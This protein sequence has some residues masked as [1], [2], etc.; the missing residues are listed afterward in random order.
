MADL[1]PTTGAID[2]RFGTLSG[3]QTASKNAEDI[4]FV[5]TPSDADSGSVAYG[6]IFVNNVMFGSR[7]QDLVI[8]GEGTG[9][10]I[11]FKTLSPTGTEL[12][13]T[14]PMAFIT[15]EEHQHYDKTYTTVNNIVQQIGA[16]DG[17]ILKNINVNGVPGNVSN[18]IASVT[19]DATQIAMGSGDASTIAQKINEAIDT[20]GVTSFA[21]QKGAIT[22]KGGSK[23]KGAVN[24]TMGGNDGKELQAAIVGLGTAA[25]EPI[26]SFADASQGEKADS[27][28][29]SI[30][31][32][33][34][35]QTKDGS[36]NVTISGADVSTLVD[37]A[38]TAKSVADAEIA[39]IGE[40]SAN[41]SSNGVSVKVITAGG[42]VTGV[43]V[44]AP[45]IE[46]LAIDASNN[47]YNSAKAYTDA[48]IQAL[49]VADSGSGYVSAVTQTNGKI[50]VTKTALPAGT[51]T[52]KANGTNVSTFTD[53]AGTNAEVNFKGG[54]N[55]TVSSSN[56][57][58]TI[59]ADAAITPNN[60]A[61]T[62]KV[63]ETTAATFTANQ[64]ANTDLAF[65]SGNNYA[66]VAAAA[67][68]ITVSV[69]GIDAVTQNSSA[70][71]ESGAV[72]TAVEGA[73]TASAVTITE[74]T[75]ADPSTILKKYTFTQNGTQIGVIDI[76]KDLVVTGGEVVEKS[77]VKY[78]R[79]HIANQTA[80]VDIPV[81]DLV[82]VY[83]AGNGIEISNTN[84]V[85]AKVATG[86]GLSVDTEGIKMALSS[87]TAA[88]AMSAADKAKLDGITDASLAAWN[89]AQPNVIESVHV[90]GK[91]ASINNKDASVTLAGTDVLVGSGTHATQTVAQA[92][93]AIEAA[94]GVSSFAGATGAIS[95]DNTST[96][97]SG[98]VVFAMGGADGSTL[99][100][101]V[102]NVAPANVVSGIATHTEHGASNGVD[103]SVTTEAGQV[104]AVTVNAP[105]FSSIYETKADASAKKAALDASI[106]VLDT[107]VSA[108]ETAIETINTKISTKIDP[109]LNAFDASLKNHET[110][111]EALESLLTWKTLY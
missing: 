31:I 18:N 6:T 65:A 64:S 61:L 66:T 74:S 88:G 57:T 52:V 76:P 11:V 24:L 109:S 27:A 29:Q 86:N 17:S 2:F 42:S 59:A 12:V 75:P 108:N 49:T 99:T 107:S 54:N 90:N 69:N 81:A 70:L 62:F 14:A 98:H 51:F 71:V 28:V 80:P 3:Y 36:G 93:E 58:I 15:V 16:I 55:I 89:A 23:A 22:I 5:Y 102:E 77:G 53:N 8:S 43:E 38:A 83:T 21:G 39:A 72:Y 10:N 87:S 85:S 13:N 94:A 104:S 4:Y 103:V 34:T 106:H 25:Y 45:N 101:T 95:V 78:L 46:Q 40:A 44:G 32:G 37:L 105:N 60:G 20:A 41:N 97:T 47:A 68:S 91:K 63:G 7:V 96:N 9:K 79:L 67:G 56:G 30:K 35:T 92:I 19:I 100:A 110:R 111:I 73:K 1:K 48:S 33:N 82:D 84:V 26:E 50:A